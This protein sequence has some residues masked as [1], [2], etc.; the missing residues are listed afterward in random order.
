MINVNDE[1]KKIIV[2]FRGSYAEQNF[3][4]DLLLVLVPW[5]GVNP[6]VKVHSG[7]LYYANSIYAQVRSNL[8]PLAAAHPDYKIVIGG[9]SLGSALATLTILRLLSTEPAF[10]GQDS[11]FSAFLYAPPRVGDVAFAQ[12]ANS[13]GFD[14]A[15][16]VHYADLV[17]HLFPPLQGYAHF[18]T[19]YWIDEVDG[20]QTVICRSDLTEDPDCS[21][22]LAP[23]YDLT[24]HFW[25]YG[26]SYFNCLLED[27][28]NGAVQISPLPVLT[29][30]VG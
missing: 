26:V 9:H 28:V 2:T 11:R 21:N 3:D 18:G 15:R 30:V 29:N 23:V 25:Y 13:F 27:P 6:D 17:P 4:V 19:E 5:A 7:F 20:N 10:Q 1:D 14:C 22:S 16:I 8:L 12:W 24:Q